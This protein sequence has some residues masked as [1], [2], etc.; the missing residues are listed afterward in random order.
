MSRTW[1]PVVCIRKPNTPSRTSDSAH[2][3]PNCVQEPLRPKAAPPALRA[4]PPS[5]VLTPRGTVGSGSYLEQGQA[6]E[7]THRKRSLQGNHSC[8]N[9]LAGLS[10]GE[11]PASLNHLET[12]S[13]RTGAMRSARPGNTPLQPTSQLVILKPTGFQLLL[14]CSRFPTPV[15]EG[16]SPNKAGCIAATWPW[17]P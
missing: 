10:V 8:R 5:L 14:R 12:S 17:G 3:L 15:D 7:Q 1:A 13:R 16:S 2:V 6:S 9:Q 4:V 11:E